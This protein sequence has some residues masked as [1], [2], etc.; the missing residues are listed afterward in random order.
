MEPDTY[1][2]SATPRYANVAFAMLSEWPSAMKI[3]ARILGIRTG[4][5]KVVLITINQ[6]CLSVITL[7]TLF[8]R[9]QLSDIVETWMFVLGIPT[10]SNL[11]LPCR[12]REGGWRAKRKERKVGK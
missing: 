6:T 11:V 10:F 7:Q 8:G 9:S 1:G 4:W 5:F 2:C 3:Y 12:A